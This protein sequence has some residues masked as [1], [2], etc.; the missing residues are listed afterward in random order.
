MTT[1]PVATIAMISAR[2][3]TLGRE[4][5]HGWANCMPAAVTAQEQAEA[6][7]TPGMHIAK[8]LIVMERDGFVM[9]VMPA[10]T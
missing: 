8:V 9:A 10:A 2:D 7:H 6:M 3:L 5:S 1:W 4:L